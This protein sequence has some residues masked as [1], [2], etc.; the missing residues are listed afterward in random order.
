MFTLC[1]DPSSDTLVRTVQMRD[2]NISLQKEITKIIPNYHP[3]LPL[4]YSSA[5]FELEVQSDQCLHL[6]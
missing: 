6:R 2:H 5:S 1:C 4:I 3:I